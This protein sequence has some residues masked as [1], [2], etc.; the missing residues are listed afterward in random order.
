MR[1]RIIGIIA[2]KGSG[3]TFH[4][5]RMIA[6]GELGKVAVFDMLHEDAYLHCCDEI[7]IGEPKKFA[8]AL[9]QPNIKIAYRPI[10]FEQVDG[11]MH[12]PEFEQVYMRLVYPLGNITIVIDEAHLLCSPATC[13]PMLVTANLIGRHRELSIV[14]ITQRFAGVSRAL[15]ANTDEFFFYKIIEPRDLS[16]I[17]ERCGSDVADRVANLRRLD[18]DKVTGKVIPGEIL[19]WSSYEGVKENELQKEVDQDTPAAGS[20]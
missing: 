7:I 13:P 19:H 11:E 4:V 18:Y 15:T 9:R 10:I 3:K 1:N 2:P 8:E 16:G 6:S 14:Y 17:R 20:D 12:S 5:S